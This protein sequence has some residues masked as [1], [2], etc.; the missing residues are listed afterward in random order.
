MKANFFPLPSPQCDEPAFTDP[1]TDPACPDG[2]L[3]AVAADVMRE[4]SA[5]STSEGKMVGLLLVQAP[6]GRWGYL[7]AFSGLWEGGWHLPGFVAPAFDEASRNN[8][9][10]VGALMVKALLAQEAALRSS[11]GFVN[12]HAAWHDQQ[13]SHQQAL[14]QLGE[15]HKAAKQARAQQRQRLTQSGHATAEALLALEQASRADKAERRAL[16]QAQSA[17]A[18]PVNV[19]WQR[20]ARRAAALERQRL[21]LCRKL[22]RAIADT[23]V[24][25]NARGEA[26]RLR[27]LFAPGDPPSGAGDCAAPKL[28]AYAY[29]HGLRPRALAEF[30][31]G[32]SPPTGG[33]IA[34][35][36]YPSCK[37]KCGPILGFMLQGLEVHQA[38]AQTQ[39]RTPAILFE[40]EWL[41]VLDKPASLLSVP[42][43]SPAPSLLT[44]LQEQRPG[45]PPGPW[46]VHRLDQDTSG[47][48]LAAKTF[49]VYVQ[50]QRQFLHREVQKR[51]TAWV[52]GVV[53]ADE[54]T[55]T[56][57][58]R[59]DVD[60]RPRQIVDPHHGKFAET[61]WAV[62]ERQPSRTKL[63][64]WPLTGRTHQLRVHVS[65]TLGLGAPIE[66]D[67]LYGTPGARLMLHAESLAFVH[68]ITRARL[69]IVSACPF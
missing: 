51:Y 10:P 19:V 3:R 34:G 11:P 48:V 32:P 44:W 36:F 27:Q 64:L 54:G 33:R 40:D 67:R 68:P 42:G 24:L 58:L 16:V 8:I 43:R 7:K 26:A 14:A 30:W 50:L 2:L 52:D 23:Y 45:N 65:H 1:F 63:T 41:I 22:M 6:G 5:L 21:A 66:G 39:P 59:L 20:M 38:P 13:T 46:L 35:Q 25:R 56:L 53:V 12:A 18:L 49:D 37:G 4:L 29:A 28:L 9:E 47:V 55:I 61:R 57:P 69:T 62:R 17:A 15:K 31:W 60:D